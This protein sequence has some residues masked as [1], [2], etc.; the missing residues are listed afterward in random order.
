VVV[1]KT[2]MPQQDT[3]QLIGFV[4][5]D[6][7]LSFSVMQPKMEIYRRALLKDP[8]VRAWPVSSVATAAPTTP[9]CWCAQADQRAQG[10]CAKGDRAPAQGNAQV[11]GGRLFLMADQDCNW[12]AVAATRPLAVPLHPAKR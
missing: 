7:G 12:A 4:R 9:S 3:G 8:A 11:P 10:K 1:P 6:D 2:L 5:G